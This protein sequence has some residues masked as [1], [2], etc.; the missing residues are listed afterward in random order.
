MK[1]MN[2]LNFKHVKKTLC[3]RKR[4]YAFFSYAYRTFYTILSNNIARKKTWQMS[5]C[6]S[7]RCYT[8]VYTYILYVYTVY[9]SIQYV[10]CYLLV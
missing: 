8:V 3:Q 10:R 9:I 7:I 6:Y 2:R 5:E 4:E 1:S